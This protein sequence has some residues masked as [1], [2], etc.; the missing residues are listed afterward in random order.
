MN[1]YLQYLLA[2]L[3]A[4]LIGAFPSGVVATKLAG[5]PDVRHSGSR[6]TGGTNT[7]RLVWV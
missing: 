2:A 4:Y 3:A 5:A 6:H 1:I 7:M